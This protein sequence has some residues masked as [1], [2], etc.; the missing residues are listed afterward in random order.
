MTRN[1][2]YDRRRRRE[3]RDFLRGF[4]LTLFDGPGLAVKLPFAALYPL[5]AVWVWNQQ[6][7]AV[8]LAQGSDLIS[9]VLR[10]ILENI[11]PIAIPDYRRRGSA[12]PALL[13]NRQEGGGRRTA[14][15][16]ACEPRRGGPRPAPQAAGRD[17]S[18][19]HHLGV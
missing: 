6:E 4:P 2:K 12:N 16:G 17:L 9:P 8:A 18:Q 15:G 3:R 5:G 11:L 14:P 10:L 13:S 1:E 7:Q 19:Y